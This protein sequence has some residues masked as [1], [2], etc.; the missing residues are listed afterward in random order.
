MATSETLSTWRRRAATKGALYPLAKCAAALHEM[1]ICED[2]NSPKA[3]KYERE[4]QRAFRE[5]SRFF[6]RVEHD[7]H[8]GARV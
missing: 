3:A 8:S 2:L 1:H 6:E 7:P 4:A 5:A